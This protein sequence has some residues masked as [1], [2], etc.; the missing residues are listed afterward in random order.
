MPDVSP[1]LHIGPAPPAWSSHQLTGFLAAVSSAADERTAVRLAVQR[2]AQA[3]EAE[4]VAFV[5]QGEVRAS[6]GFPPDPALERALVE[7]ADGSATTVVAPGAGECS[8]VALSVE[9]DPPAGLVLARRVN[10]GFASDELDLARG[11]ARVLG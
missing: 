1:T 11:M 2:V 9:D 4:V 8:A 3:L 7:V 10:R 5:R 6:I